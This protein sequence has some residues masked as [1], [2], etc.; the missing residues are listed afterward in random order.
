MFKTFWINVGYIASVMGI[1]GVSVANIVSG[2]IQAWIA[3]SVLIAFLVFSSWRV[4]IFTKDRLSQKYPFGYYPLSSFARWTTSD[5]VISTYEIFRHIQVKNPYMSFFEHKFN[6]SGS[7]CPELMSDLQECGEV[8]AV[9]GT[10]DKSVKFLF[11]RPRFY[12]EVEIVHIKM[13]TDDEDGLASPHL[14]LNVM[15]PTNM[16]AFRIELLHASRAY[17]GKLAR[18]VRQAAAP[19]AIGIGSS[20]VEE[21]VCMVSFDSLTKSYSW[22]LANPEPGYVYKIV[23]EKPKMNGASSRRTYK[24]KST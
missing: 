12:N 19:G 23:W 14:S 18:V 2:S 10:N 20:A 21:N 15:F 22:Q 9:A 1:G 3:L 7:K 6:W 13:R 24:R 17:N 16:I 5:G 4:F 11:K 8:S